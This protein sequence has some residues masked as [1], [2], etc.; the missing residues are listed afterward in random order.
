MPDV[1]GVR[2]SG[3]DLAKFDVLACDPKRIE[4]NLKRVDKIL[5]VSLSQ[6]EC[7]AIYGYSVAARRLAPVVLTNRATALDQSQ[8]TR[9]PEW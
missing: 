8:A 5:R 6:P 1:I 3:D 9:A 7:S 2:N 4:L